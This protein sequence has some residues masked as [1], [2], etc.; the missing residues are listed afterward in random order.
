MKQMY[1]SKYLGLKTVIKRCPSAPHYQKHLLLVNQGKIFT[2]LPH[3][4]VFLTF[5][6][7]LVAT[8]NLI[9]KNQK[10][11]G[12]VTTKTGNVNDNSSG[13]QEGRKCNLR[14]RDALFSLYRN[15][16]ILKN[17]LVFGKC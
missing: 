17:T 11:C 16:Q 2:H 15:I 1:A 12:S 13:M 10:I 3:K 14:A 4:T 8:D 7:E 9:F 6:E 5:Y